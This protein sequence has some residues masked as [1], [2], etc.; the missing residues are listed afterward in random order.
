MVKHLP[1][2]LNLFFKV[3]YLH[4]SFIYDD[5]LMPMSDRESPVISTC[6][7][8]QSLPTE[9]GLPSANVSWTEPRATDNAGDVTLTY[10]GPGTN[11]GTF[12]IGVTL[13]S[14]TAVDGAG[15]SASCAFAISIMGKEHH[16]GADPGL[17]KRGGTFSTYPNPLLY[18]LQVAEKANEGGGDSDTM[19]SPKRQLSQQLVTA[20]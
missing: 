13:I 18:F 2:Y 17:L 14:Y 1:P 12:S 10:N 7:S 9:P 16:A 15:N 4:S 11:G 6:P 3:I 8:S 19:F 5:F 20:S